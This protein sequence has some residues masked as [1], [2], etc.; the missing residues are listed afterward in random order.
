LTAAP[1]VTQSQFGTIK[2]RVVWGG[3]DIPP[4]KVLEAQGKAEKDPNICAK[5]Q[6][7]LSRELV[8]DPKTKGV[9][10]A[11]AFVFRPKGSNPDAVKALVDGQPLIVLDQ[12]N[13]E[14]QPY[15]LP[16]HQ[17]QTLLIKSSDATNH[18]VRL[19]PFTN[20]GLNTTLPPQGQ[21]PVK[22]VAERLPIKVACD[23]HPWM[24]GWVMVF[25]HPFFATTGT[26]GSFEIKGVPAGTQSLV[27]W[28]ETVG[29]VTPGGGR[30]MPVEVKPGEVTNVGVIKLEPKKG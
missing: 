27:I 25:D 17:D 16:M 26:D 2:G 13:C 4:V 18:N 3:D 15:L 6:P 9:S 22:L 7:I 12:V 1:L 10:H 28:Q 20:P 14:F 21:F 29:Y 24:H 23:I 11:F 30:G 5:N 8:V 19:T